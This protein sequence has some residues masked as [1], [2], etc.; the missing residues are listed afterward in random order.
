MDEGGVESVFL[1][2]LLIL[3][4]LLLLLFNGI[5]WHIHYNF[6]LPALKIKKRS[7]LQG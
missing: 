7:I 4:L 5:N 1:L 6:G 3:L 2:L